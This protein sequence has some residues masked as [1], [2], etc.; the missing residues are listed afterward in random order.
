MQP[1]NVLIVLTLMNILMS[2]HKFVL[3][4]SLLFLFLESLFPAF[5]SFTKFRCVLLWTR[6]SKYWLTDLISVPW[7]DM[8]KHGEIVIRFIY[9]SSLIFTN[10]WIVLGIGIYKSKYTY[11]EYTYKGKYTLYLKTL[12]LLVYGRDFSWIAELISARTWDLT[13]SQSVL[14]T[15]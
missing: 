10:T 7:R 12:F 1:V 6:W 2:K 9:I 14:K 5:T 4:I 13:S 3:V 11:T 15:D 8:R